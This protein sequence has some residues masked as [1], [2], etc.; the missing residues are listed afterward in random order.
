M[1][2]VMTINYL[3]GWIDKLVE[4][5]MTS[6]VVLEPLM[7][8]TLQRPDHTTSIIDFSTISLVRFHRENLN[9]YQP[10]DGVEHIMR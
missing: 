8:P 9:L 10:L 5:I 2:L 1:S 7:Y 4:C 6:A 3:N